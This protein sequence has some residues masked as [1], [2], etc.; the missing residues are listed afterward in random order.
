M[1]VFNRFRKKKKSVTFFSSISSCVLP[2]EDI[3]WFNRSETTSRLF[4]TNQQATDLLSRRVEKETTKEE[5]RQQDDRVQ[6]HVTS[7]YK[8]E[9]KKEKENEKSEQRTANDRMNQRRGEKKLAIFFLYF[10]P[11]VAHQ[12][13]RWL[14]GCQ[15]VRVG[16]SF[17]DQDGLCVADWIAKKK[18]GKKKTASTRGTTIEKERSQDERTVYITDYRLA[19]AR[20]ITIIVIITLQKAD[21]LSFSIYPSKEME[22][23][24]YKYIGRH[25]QTK[26][27]SK[28]EWIDAF[29]TASHCLVW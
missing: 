21:R 3:D 22:K 20:I 23:N 10:A 13:F 11:P 29:M 7:S 14:L 17:P 9:R 15:A 26:G 19:S 16:F 4:S 25:S 24:T 27:K 5:K 28:R 12:Q 18:R 8:K 6:T 2:I 1:S